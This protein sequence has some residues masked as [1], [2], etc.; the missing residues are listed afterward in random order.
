MIQYKYNITLYCYGEDNI[1]SIIHFI[2]VGKYGYASKLINSIKKGEKFILE[3]PKECGILSA[4]NA[5]AVFMAKIDIKK[6][7]SIQ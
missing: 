7:D 4:I 5:G 1:P 6:L 2:H 3:T